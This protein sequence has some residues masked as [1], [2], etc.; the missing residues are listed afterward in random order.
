[1]SDLRELLQHSVSPPTRARIRP[2]CGGPGGPVA[3]DVGW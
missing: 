2:S 1:M 3:P